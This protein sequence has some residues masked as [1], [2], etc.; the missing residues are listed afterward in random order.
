MT[1][2]EKRIVRKKE[3][4]RVLDK[5]EKEIIVEM[6]QF[7]K[8]Q[9]IKTLRASKEIELKKLEV[10]KAKEECKG[11]NDLEQNI[12]HTRDGLGKREDRGVTMSEGN[13]VRLL[14][15]FM[16]FSDYS[17][18][19]LPILD[20]GVREGW[21]LEFLLKVRYKNVKG[22]EITPEAVALAR[23]KKL[24]VME[25]DVRKM[26]A[27]NIFGTITAIHVLEHVS[28][29][30]KVIDVIYNALILNGILYLEIPLETNFSPFKSAH[31]CCFPEPENL[32]VLFDK[33]KWKLLQHEVVIM[34]AAGSKKNCMSVFRKID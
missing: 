17:N 1:K 22:I 5:R 16:F 12:V 20:I 25:M 27:K 9:E 3:E 31:F 28:N 8:L 2:L 33:S 34:N 32:F 15:A 19:S 24:D 13:F 30:K 10:A 7:H 18:K 21:F 4:L 29:P 26:V 23:S 6:Y 14:K 11:L